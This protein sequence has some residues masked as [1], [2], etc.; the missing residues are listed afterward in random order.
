M[1]SEFT[2]DWCC[3][4][5]NHLAMLEDTFWEEEIL[6]ESPNPYIQIIVLK[7]FQNLLKNQQMENTSQKEMKKG[8]QKIQARRRTTKCALQK[9]TVRFLQVP[10]RVRAVEMRVSSLKTKRQHRKS[11]IELAEGSK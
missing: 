5:K 6:N 11:N 7:I 4:H 8:L 2:K 1:D 9:Q 10:V 3:T